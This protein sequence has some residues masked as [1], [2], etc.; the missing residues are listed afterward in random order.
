MD[1]EVEKKQETSQQERPAPRSR[2]KSAA[3]ARREAAAAGPAGSTNHHRPRLL[4]GVLTAVVLA[5][6]VGGY[7][8]KA[9]GYRDTFLPHTVINGVKVSGQTPQEARD[10]ISAG[11]QSYSLVLKL[12]DGTSRSISGADMGLHTRFDGSLDEIIRQQ[13]PFFWPRYLIKGPSYKIQTMVVFDEGKL[14]HQL[15]KLDCFDPA[16]VTPPSDAYLSDYVSGQGYSI[17]PAAEG[18]ELDP[19]RVKEMAAEHVQTLNGEMDLNALGCYREPSIQSDNSALAAARDARNHY[20]NTTITYTFGSVSQVLDGDTIHQ[21]LVF[22]GDQVSL[23]THKISD[24]VKD[25]AS[26]YNTAYKQ[27]PFITSYGQTVEVSGRYGWK[28]DQAGETAELTRLLQA[29]ESITREPVYSQTAASHDG[30][31]VGTTYAE[32]NL[33]AQH[34]F[35]YKDGKKILESDFVSGNPS[36]GHTTPPG[37]YTITYKQ[38]DAVLKG[39]GYASP[40]KYWMPFNGGIGFHD[41]SWRSSFGGAIYKSG[42]SHGC[43]NMPYITAEE[44]YQNVYAGMPVVCYNL[45]G[46]ENSRPSKE[47]GS[48][49]RPAAPPHSAAPA[50]APAPAPA[51]SAAPP[52]P[53]ESAAPSAPAESA[54]APA[55][56]ES[57]A[58][59]PA[60]PSAPAAPSGS[61]QTP[62]PA[63]SQ[64][65]SIEPVEQNPAPSGEHAPPSE[66]AAGYGPAFD[67]PG[68]GGENGPGVK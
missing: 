48:P 33:T 23:D 27:R 63:P 16:R 29:G 53:A 50:P 22:D 42:G 60:P 62:P 44:L 20:V 65:I 25:L 59:G 51:E 36:K 4:M 9:M 18:N 26:K 61:G 12:R 43:V 19:D 1:K 68:P 52:A 13:N 30:A 28:I 56:A 37:I 41:A 7:V 54:A 45:P 67:N 17:V 2:S 15:G 10:R 55:P 57:P 49:P 31:D 3:K 38:K 14:D 8:Y 40:V 5:A 34:L 39:Q 35:L 6:C 21:W 58:P 32:V 64:S 47:S 46:T 24:Y 11:I 66:T